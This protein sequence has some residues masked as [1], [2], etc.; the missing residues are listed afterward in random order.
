MITVI[1]DCLRGASDRYDFWVSFINA[2]KIRAVAEIGVYKGEFSARILGS[3]SSIERYYMID[4][5]RHLEDWH[6]PANESDVE[7][8]QAF[9]TAMNVTRPFA[10]KRIVLRGKTREII[11]ELPDEELDLVYIDGDHTLRGI[12]IDLIRS[13]PKVRPGGWI[14][15]DD[16][17]SSIW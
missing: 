4:P 8:Q 9:Q 12:T 11:D 5:W 6:K 13:F 3:C 16:F 1:E 7:M 10:R 17:T 14:G 2:M 15:G